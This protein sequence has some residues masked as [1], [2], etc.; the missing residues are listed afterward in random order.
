MKLLVRLGLALTRWTERW[1]PD[2]WVIAIMLTLVV[3]LLAM[4]IGGTSATG[5]LDAWGKGLW[6]LLTL[7]MQFTLMMVV[8][9]ACAVS[10]PVKRF[11]IWLASRP[12]PSRPRQA[13]VL[14]ALVATVTAWLNWALSLVVTA[15]FLP[16]VV[17]ANPGVDFRLLVA[18]AYLGIGTVWHAG[19]SGSAPLILATPDNFL[20]KAG[21]LTETIPITQTLFTPFNLLYG[22]GVGLLGIVIVAALV[23]PAEDAVR[24][25]AQQ[26]NRLAMADTVRSKP[27]TMTPADRL[28]WWP[29]WS[30]ITGGAMLLYFGLQ[31][32]TLSLGQ[33]WTIDNY[34]LLFFALG[35]LLHWHP[36]SFL[37][38]C[39]EG[40]RNTWGIVIQY[41]LYAGIFGLMSYTELGT[42]LTHF[43]AS[44]SSPRL[45]PLIVYVYSAVLNYFAP[46]GGSKWIIEASY[47]IPAG[48][49]LGVSVPTVTLSY[50]YDDMATD[51]IQPL[52]AIPIL[53]V[54]GLRFGDIMGYCFILTGLL[55]LFNVFALLLIPLQ[56]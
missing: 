17:R 20:I 18:S 55:F 56:L 8:A 34:N 4:T 51:L 35:L 19:L 37:Q 45:F 54:A 23:P 13:I 6:A 11:F 33:A 49:A 38:A 7:T 12:N 5:V 22:L 9:Y 47:L 15:A 25:S 44:A 3:V 40:I 53:T 50:A 16:F 32:R 21:V 46:S 42:V 1:V 30:L 28:D 10:P 29:G 27:E 48:Q 41:P 52:F 36:K 26:A 14:M 39:E 43:F 24:V 31:V 2:S